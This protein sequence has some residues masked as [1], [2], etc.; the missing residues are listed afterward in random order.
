MEVKEAPSLTTVK[1]KTKNLVKTWKT[2]C[3]LTYL[4]LSQW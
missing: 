3:V 4:I 1:I 2:L